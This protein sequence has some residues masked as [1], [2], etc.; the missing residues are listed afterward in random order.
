MLHHIS[1]DHT[2]HSHW[3]QP[4]L[5]KLYMLSSLAKV[6]TFGW[7]MGQY[8]AA[9]PKR[10]HGFSN[11]RFSSLLDL[12]VYRRAVQAKHKKIETVRRYTTK[13]GKRGYTGTKHLKQ[14]QFGPQCSCML[15][16]ICILSYIRHE[17][18]SMF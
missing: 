5:F 7:W 10:H 8:G 1:E 9:S 3:N 2:M 13:D 17:F 18:T 16:C 6:Y 12:G 11:N 14:T 4:I 15:S